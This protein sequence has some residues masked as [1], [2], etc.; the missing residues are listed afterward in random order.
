VWPGGAENRLRLF[1]KQKYRTVSP[2]PHAKKTIVE[3]SYA[4]KNAQRNI[5]AGKNCPVRVKFPLKTNL[6]MH[7]KRFWVLKHLK[8]KLNFLLR[9]L[10]NPRVLFDL[11]RRQYF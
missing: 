1:I 8:N 2:H 9:V 4:K 7:F 5:R 3:Q 11:S 10:T 6:A